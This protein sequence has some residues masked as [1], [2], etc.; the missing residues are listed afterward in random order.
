MTARSIRNLC[1]AALAAAILLSAPASAKVRRRSNLALVMNGQNFPDPGVIRTGDGWH[2]FSTNG[3]VNN[4]KIHVQMAY[5]PDFKSWTF[6]GTKDAM[7]KLAPWIH[8]ATPKIWAPDVTQLPDGSFI[9][10][11]CASLAVKPETHCLGYATSKNAEG[12][13]VDNSN[14]AWICPQSHGGAIDPAGFLDA[15]PN[16][17]YVVYKVDGNSIGHGGECG[18][19]V[20][21]IVPTPLI[22]QQVNV[23]NGRD[24][25]GSPIQILTNGPANGPYVEAPSLTYMGGKYVLFFSS[26]C[27]A[28]PKYDVSYAIS[29]NITG[30]YKKY[31]PLF[32]TG[33]LGLTAPGGMDVAINGD[34]AVFHADFVKKDLP[35][36]GSSN[37]P[38]DAGSAQVIEQAPWA[39]DGDLPAAKI[40]ED[41][42]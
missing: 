18:N 39:N 29:D 33:T 26:Q 36:G 1:A 7:P 37:S 41:A 28:T 19:T 31:G 17:R 3:V 14:S 10:Y 11:Y 25:I 12:P 32:V 30:P 2:A 20:K 34:H 24:L 35:G 27:Y 5:T 6:R 4:Q 13:F 21:P 22:L 42:L 23:N 38:K 15:G 8:A 16:K 9:M 40:E